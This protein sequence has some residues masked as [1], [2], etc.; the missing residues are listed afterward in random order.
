MFVCFR[1]Q[2]VNYLTN[3]AALSR[4]SRPGSGVTWKSSVRRDTS[5]HMTGCG[6]SRMPVTTSYTNCSRTIP[7]GW[8]LCTLSLPCALRVPR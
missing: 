8:M 2:P 5:K 6:L 7:A 3:E 4:A 1:E